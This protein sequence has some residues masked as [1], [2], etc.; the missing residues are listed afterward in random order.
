MKLERREDRCVADSD[1]GVFLVASEIGWHSG[2]A[3]ASEI[4]ARVLPDWLAATAK[5]A[6]RDVDLIESAVADAVD[7]ARREMIAFAQTNPHFSRMAATMAFA[8]VVDRTLYVT[9][10]GNCRA[11]LLHRDRLQRLSKDRLA[12]VVGVEPLGEA[13][14][15]DAFELGEV[16][17]LLLCS[18][19]LTDSVSDGEL[20]HFLRL[21]ECPQTSADALVNVAVKNGTHNDVT[22]VVVDLA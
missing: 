9:C 4:L 19:G 1:R 6:W 18:E 12:D 14:S 15:V 21:G 20:Q 11:Y 3:E 22:C 10:V 7:A 8:V 5:C 2:R 16:N 13:I 17:R